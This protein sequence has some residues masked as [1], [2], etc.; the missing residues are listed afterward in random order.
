MR[1]DNQAREAHIKKLKHE[2]LQ[3]E[4]KKKKKIGGDAMAQGRKRKVS[5]AINCKGTDRERGER[6]RH[7]PQSQVHLSMAGRQEER[8]L[9][10][11][12]KKQSVTRRSDRLAVTL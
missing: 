12:K 4:K 6:K 8:D 7:L 10:R 5:I 3:P 2:T 11:T 1:E 9:M